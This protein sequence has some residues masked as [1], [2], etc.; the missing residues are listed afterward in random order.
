MTRSRSRSP[1]RGSQSPRRTSQRRDS[2]PRSPS[3]EPVKTTIT[4]G[5]LTKNVNEGHIR[6]IFGSY[7]NIKSIHF[8]M[9][10]RCLLTEVPLLY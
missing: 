10:T 3:V 4:V 7:G 9:N 6:E 2:R 8:P 5:N 1:D